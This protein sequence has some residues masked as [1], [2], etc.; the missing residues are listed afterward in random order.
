MLLRLLLTYWRRRECILK[1]VMLLKTKLTQQDTVWVYIWDDDHIQ[2]LDEKTGNAYGILKL[3]KE[4]MLLRLLLT[5]WGRR[6]CILKVVMLLKT[7]LTQ[8]DT[9]NFRITNRLVRVFFA[10]IQK[11]LEHPSLVY[12]ISHL[13]PLNPPFIGVPKV[14]LHQTT[15]IHL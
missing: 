15:L 4:S 12:T 13:L 9:K 7:K 5:Y 8:Q 10:I 3:F 6:V 14:S 1:V 11:R 2:R